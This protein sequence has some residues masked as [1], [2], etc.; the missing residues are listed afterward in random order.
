MSWSLNDTGK[1]RVAALVESGVLRGTN[2]VVSSAETK[3]IETAEPLANRLGCELEIRQLMHENDRSSTGFLP[4]QEFEAV[5]DQFFAEPAVSVRGWETARQA[6]GRIVSE[7]EYCLDQP[8]S[9]DVLFVGHGGVGTLLLCH[10][11]SVPISRDLD[12][13]AGGGGNFFRFSI[14][15]REV[16]NRWLPMER[17]A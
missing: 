9:G 12:Q 2:R 14:D 10:L 17:M 4:P 16:L 5:A 7:V 6:Q 13:G 15:S 3:A 1:S 8:A 11:L